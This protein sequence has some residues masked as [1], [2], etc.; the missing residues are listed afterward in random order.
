MGGP[1]WSPA[2]SP[3]TPW[4]GPVHRVLLA[5]PRRVLTTSRSDQHPC[6]TREETEARGGATARPAAVLRQPKSAP[7]RTQR[8]RSGPCVCARHGDPPRS[9]GA[10]TAG[11][12]PAHI[13]GGT[14]TEPLR[15][16]QR[17]SLRMRRE[18]VLS[19]QPRSPHETCQPGT[20][21]AAPGRGRT[22]GS[23]WRRRGARSSRPRT[24]SRPIAP[25]LCGTAVP[26]LTAQGSS[27]LYAHAGA[28][29]C[30]LKQDVP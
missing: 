1:Q 18:L 23:A 26:P 4:A 21:S 10:Q 19:Q 24:P 2:P 15:E 3:S 13:P 17:R 6:F 8:A 9:C 28:P 30:R 22:G 16:G 5:L 12:A 29:D 25:A 27:A 20:R 11:P 7:P 14:D